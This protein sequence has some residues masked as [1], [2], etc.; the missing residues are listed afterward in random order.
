MVIDVLMQ[1]Y[2][3]LFAIIYEEYTHYMLIFKYLLLYTLS[4]C[5]AKMSVTFLSPF[6][7]SLIWLIFKFYKKTICLAISLKRFDLL[8]HVIKT[9]IMSATF[10]CLLDIIIK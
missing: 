7:C 4:L 10:L 6:S 3:M 9:T 5:S 1:C 2:V 8:K